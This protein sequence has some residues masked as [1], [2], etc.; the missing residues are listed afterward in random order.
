MRKSNNNMEFHA[1]YEA[2]FINF[3]GSKEE[4]VLIL[5]GKFCVRTLGRV[6]PPWCSSY[7]CSKIPEGS[8]RDA[9]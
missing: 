5:A 2:V 4:F 8:C 1:H 7:L 6:N 3:V 9:T